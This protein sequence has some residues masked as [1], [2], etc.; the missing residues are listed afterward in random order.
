MR[1]PIAI[2]LGAI[3]GALSRY[4]LNLWAVKISG[5]DF[6]WGIIAI[7]LSGCLMMGAIATIAKERIFHLAP[8]LYLTIATG[9]L[10]SYTTFSTYGLDTVNLAL[11]RSGSIAF[12]YWLGSAIG[13]VTCIHLGTIIAHWFRP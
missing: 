4:Y 10:G 8:D 1:I 2:S 11:N 7:N 9:F 13:G 6:P 5:T 3:A 12:S